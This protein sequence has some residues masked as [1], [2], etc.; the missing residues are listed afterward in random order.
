MVKVK[1]KKQIKVF[2]FYS[3]KLI[4]LEDIKKTL[5][6]KMIKGFF[7]FIELNFVIII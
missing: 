7:Y 3:T 4:L 2:V 6:E 1:V 5:I